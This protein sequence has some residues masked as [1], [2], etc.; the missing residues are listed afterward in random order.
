MYKVA[1]A[2]IN[3]AGDLFNESLLDY[4]KVKYKRSN[5]FGANLTMLGGMLSALLPSDKIK[6]KVLQGILSIKEDTTAPLHVWG[7]GFLVGSR[8]GELKR[9]NLHLHSLRG[10]L[11][12]QKL[13]GLLSKKINIPLC[14]PGLLAKEF[15]SNNVEKKYRVGIIPHYMEQSMPIFKD[16]ANYYNSSLLIDITRPCSEVLQE[17]ASCDMII[18][19]SLHGLIFSDS[20][21]VPNMHIVVSN[22]LAGDGF[23]FKDYYSSYGL[24]DT[25][26]LVSSDKFPELSNIEKKYQINEKEVDDK[27]EAMIK[28]FPKGL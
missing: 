5:V 28:A 19:S 12:R 23:K 24:E 21:R 2:R 6:L 13:E 3:N 11:S 18:S 16:M 7:T 25:P 4:F 17:I 26:F 27:I 10:D 9:K 22:K 20:L 1:Y 8:Q 14:D 15:V